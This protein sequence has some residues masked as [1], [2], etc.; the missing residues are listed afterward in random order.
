VLTLEHGRIPPTI[1]Y[2][3]PDPD[4]DLD[5]VPNVAREA[6]LRVVLSNSFGLG[7]QNAAAVFRQ[8][9]AQ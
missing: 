9:E 7:G 6:T 2:V 3:T 5:I 8:Y 4:C 1:N